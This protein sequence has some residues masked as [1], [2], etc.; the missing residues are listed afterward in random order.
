[1]KKDNVMTSAEYKKLKIAHQQTKRGKK[2][3]KKR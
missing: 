3:R 2:K 1:M